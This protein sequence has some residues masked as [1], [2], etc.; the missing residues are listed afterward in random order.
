MPEKK[1]ILTVDV[2]VK[3]T[4]IFQTMLSYMEAL[5]ELLGEY[6]LSEVD[7]RKLNEISGKFFEV[8]RQQI[9]LHRKCS[10]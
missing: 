8:T 4:E 9:Y 3:D 2:S 10:Y 1:S 7:E 6:P 5:I